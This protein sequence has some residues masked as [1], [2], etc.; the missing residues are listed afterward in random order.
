V[1]VRREW[2]VPFGTIRALPLLQGRW[3]VLVV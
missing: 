3:Q 2:I 1:A